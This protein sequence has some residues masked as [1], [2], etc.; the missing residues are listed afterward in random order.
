MTRLFMAFALAC[1][2]SVGASTAAELTPVN[3]YSVHLARY[4][5]VVYYT[6]GGDGYDVVATLGAGA[7]EQPIRFIASL[8]PGQKMV[9]SVPRSV[10]QPSSDLEIRRDGDV[11]VLNDPDTA[12]GVDLTTIHPTPAALGE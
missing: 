3:G 8:R 1:C 11:M 5:G 2:G 9:I 12:A 6:V 4:A 7:E 10:G